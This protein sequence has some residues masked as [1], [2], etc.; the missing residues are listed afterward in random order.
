MTLCALN[1][2]VSTK[3][4]PLKFRVW[5]RSPSARF[6]LLI[7]RAK[8]NLLANLNF[9]MIIER[10]RSVLVCPHNYGLHYSRTSEERVRFEKSA[11][12]F[13]EPEIFWESRKRPT[14]SE[15]LLGNLRNSEE[16]NHGFL[17]E[18]GDQSLVL[19]RFTLV[20]RKIDVM[21]V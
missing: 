13:N 10:N 5:I 16:T 8:G 18:T 11:P 21:I 7:E 17:V 15:T 12:I 3:G 20:V 19:T 9:L 6:R 14:D 2:R 4:R 1:F